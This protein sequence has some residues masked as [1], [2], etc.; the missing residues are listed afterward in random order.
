M[1]V[2]HLCGKAGARFVATICLSIG[3]VAEWIHFA[4]LGISRVDTLYTCW[5]NI[6]HYKTKSVHFLVL[7]NSATK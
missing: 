2:L 7:M 6:T 1:E 4:L 3:L 5:D